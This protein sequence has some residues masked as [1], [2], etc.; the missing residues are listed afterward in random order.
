MNNFTSTHVFGLGASKVLVG[1]RDPNIF[2]I[3]FR[4]GETRY[5]EL[6]NS[7]PPAARYN[8]GSKFLIFRCVL[9]G[10]AP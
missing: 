10:G 3:M 5:Y 4:P 1:L 7:F 6:R 9:N 8:R 2:E